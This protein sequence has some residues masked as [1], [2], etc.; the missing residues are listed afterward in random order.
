MP[1]ILAKHTNTQIQIHT[2]T[3]VR[4]SASN[5]EEKDLISHQ[6]TITLTSWFSSL[7]SSPVLRAHTRT[8]R[9]WWHGEENDGFSTLSGASPS[10]KPWPRSVAAFYTSASIPADDCRSSSSGSSSNSS[11]PNDWEVFQE[12]GNSPEMWPELLCM[13]NRCMHR[14]FA[15]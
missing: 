6:K 9:A 14:P 5:T 3:D 15:A 10:T 1:I 11:S 2:H 4:C 13:C 7:A 12:R 8:S